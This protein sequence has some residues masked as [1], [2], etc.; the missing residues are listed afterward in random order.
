M[1][2]YY[3]AKHANYHIKLRDGIRALAE[4]DADI[5]GAVDAG[6]VGVPPTISTRSTPNRK[7]NV[8]NARNNALTGGALDSAETACDNATVRGNRDG[9]TASN[10]VTTADLTPTE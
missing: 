6:H 2:H 5:P 7:E 4:R 10:K 9:N 3:A 1:K 8:P